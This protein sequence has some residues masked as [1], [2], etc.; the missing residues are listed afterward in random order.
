MGEIDRMDF[1][2]IEDPAQVIK[3]ESAY[4]DVFVYDIK[5]NLLKRFESSGAE[6]ITFRLSEFEK[7]VLII[8]QGDLSY[9]IVVE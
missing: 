1:C 4:E 6:D 9:K 3:V 2:E 8:R 5:G 7:Q